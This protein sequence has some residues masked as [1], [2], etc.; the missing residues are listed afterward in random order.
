MN[1]NFFQDKNMIVTLQ[2]RNE[3]TPKASIDFSLSLKENKF[4]LRCHSLSFVLLFP[5]FCVF[6][7]Q[8]C[9]IC[10]CALP[11]KM[12]VLA[13]MHVKPFHSSFFIKDD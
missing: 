8:R 2:G 7:N 11:I 1:N 4:S 5:R 10:L 13:P 12:S 3:Q 6:I 9:N